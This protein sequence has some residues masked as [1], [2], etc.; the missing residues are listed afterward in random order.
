MQARSL[1]VVILSLLVLVSPRPARAIA[2]RTG[3]FELEID[4]PWRMEPRGPNKVYGAIP[5]QVS[6]HDADQPATSMDRLLQKIITATQEGIPTDLPGPTDVSSKLE[7][8]EQRKQEG[9]LTLM[10]YAAAEVLEYIDGYIR[11]V[12]GFELFPADILPTT[13]TLNRFQSL[14]IFEETGGIF[15]PR[16]TF[17]LAN[18]HEVER[19]VGLW[20]FAENQQV[21]LDSPFAPPPRPSHRL[22]R[23]WQGQDCSAFV[24]LRPTSEWHLTALYTPANA[25]PGQ[26]VRL[27]AEL[28]VSVVDDGVA[29]TRTYARIL[30]VHL[31]KEPLP[32][33]DAGWAY[34]DLHYHSQGTDNDGESGYSYR[35]TLQAMSALGLDFTFA[36]DHASN[37]AQIGSIQPAIDF[38]EVLH[39][40]P[41]GLR[42]LS[43]DRFAF[44]IDLLNGPLGGN[45]EVTSYPRSTGTGTELAAPQLFLGSE[46][47]VIPEADRILSFEACKEVPGWMKTIVLLSRGDITPFEEYICGTLA[48]PQPDGRELA[49][50][51][52][53]PNNGSLLSTSFYGRQHL[54]HLPVDGQRRNAFIPSNTSKYGGAT[55]RLGEILDLE[56]DQRQKGYA[57]LAHPFAN[58]TGGEIGRLG[59]D[60]LPYSKEQLADA[61]ASPYILG[62]QIWNENPLLVSEANEARPF[63]SP[64]WEA[65]SGSDHA[66]DVQQWDLQQL[67]GLDK[68]RTAALPWLQPDQPR[69]IFAAGG[70]DAHGDFNYR[71]EGHFFGTDRA[72]STA[73]GTPRNLVYVGEPQGA[74]IAGA[75][76]TGRPLSQAQVVDGLRSGNFS[77]T[78]G[79]AVRVVVDADG[80]GSID[81]E[82]VPMG[83]VH[84]QAAGGPF[85]VIVE[86]KSSEEF[87]PVAEIKLFVGVWAPGFV[88]SGMVYMPSHPDIPNYAKTNNTFFQPGTN[89]P[90]VK[91]PNLPYWYDPEPTSRLF[92]EPKTP[93]EAH[94]GKR[95][96]TIDP[97]LYLVGQDVCLDY[98]VGG[99][100]TGEPGP[101]GGSNPVPYLDTSYDEILQGQVNGSVVF[102]SYC[103][104]REFQNAKRPER[105][106]I[107]A[108]VRNGDMPGTSSECFTDDGGTRRCA[109]HQAYSNPVWVNVAPCPPSVCPIGGTQGGGSG[110]G[111]TG[112]PQKIVT[113]P[114]GT[115]T[116]NPTSTGSTPTWGTLQT[117]T[118]TSGTVTLSPIR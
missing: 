71:R 7:R 58:A 20:Q 35:G 45:R 6:I 73:I 23:R 54:L 61:Y 68:A 25:I 86:W 76:G 108:E 109:Y 22:C 98:V 67:F 89:R 87:G 114:H 29:A 95:V 57:F 10:L 53:G 40:L 111:S 41:R 44:G 13:V 32:K 102:Q 43:P 11:N 14:V 16:Q 105:M 93:E 42:D 99:S 110:S 55:R 113:Q 52:Q 91:A 28:R 84:A 47:D 33:F 30:N 1:L 115:V 64:A 75:A 17:T 4:A 96:V 12:L 94:A 69:R 90:F 59:P 80:H 78:D 27:R 101:T 51:T 24:S 118:T 49:L 88:H 65:R 83:G 62:L 92:I 79:P 63:V 48:D 2:Q 15:L 56:L 97:G 8:L 70:S 31:G 19:T 37:S 60:L 26:D 100:P 117:T 107:R 66:Y 21:G 5:I 3:D 9:I 38:W 82:D 39:P 18:I 103:G 36:T 72:A 74:A 81:P 50:D 112:L 46:V 104:R 34:G 77:V 85:K 106:F 116:L